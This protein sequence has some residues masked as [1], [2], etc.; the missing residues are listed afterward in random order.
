MRQMRIVGID[1]GLQ[2]TGY[3]VLRASA[4]RPSDT[5]SLAEAGVFRFKSSLPVHDRL[6]ELEQDLTALL[7]RSQAQ[8]VCVEKLYA[9]YAHP[10]TAIIMGH[11]RGV[12]LLVAARMGLR[13]IELPA[14]EVKRAVTGN[15]HASKQ[16]V[17][18]TVQALLALPAPPSS[19]DVSDAIAIALTGIQR[20]TPVPVSSGHA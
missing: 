6:V 4:E 5:P 17:Q 8:V 16:Q 9:H 2:R 15:G 7:A 18:S 11:A 10:T 1:P 13:L 12:I 14:T 3:A 19:T 20:A